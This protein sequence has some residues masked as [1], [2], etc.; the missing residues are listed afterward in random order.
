VKTSKAWFL[1]LTPLLLLIPLLLV[2]VVY[3]APPAPAS[4]T[5]II[6]PLNLTIIDSREAGGKIFITATST[7]S[8]LLGTFV[9]PFS[10]EVRLV[11]YPDGSI[12]RQGT[13]LCTC[14]VGGKTG[15]L[16]FQSQ[17]KGNADGSF[18]GTQSI[19]SATGELEGLH[20]QGT[21]E[22]TSFGGTY[23]GQIHFDP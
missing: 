19:I 11:I 18:Q 12:D 3:A 14:T 1:L 10:S 6:D 4:G 8:E 23:S 9:G 21:I 2:T 15:T 17:A 13:S 22:G 16:V 7:G 5:F 20:Y